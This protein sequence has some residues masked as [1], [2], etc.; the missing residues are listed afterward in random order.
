MIRYVDDWMPAKGPWWA[1]FLRLPVAGAVTI[2]GL[3]VELPNAQAGVKVYL[4]PAVRYPAYGYTY[5]HNYYGDYTPRCHWERRR[6]RRRVCWRNDYGRRKC[7][8]KRR[9]KRVKVC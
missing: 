9:W 3:A 7:R 8:W 2:T 4:G 6:V 5:D 1:T